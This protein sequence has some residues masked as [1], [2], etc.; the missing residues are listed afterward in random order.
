MSGVAFEWFEILDFLGCRSGSDA[1]GHSTGECSS[2]SFC[3]LLTS[4]IEVFSGQKNVEG[5]YGRQGREGSP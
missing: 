1:E 4:M 5:L 3:E 2:D